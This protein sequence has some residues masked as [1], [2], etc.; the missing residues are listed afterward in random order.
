MNKYSA[1]I[2][3][4]ILCLTLSLSL[5]ACGEK[6]PTAQKKPGSQSSK[7]QI[8]SGEEIGSSQE[9]ASSGEST[10]NS[11]ENNSTDG[12][13]AAEDNNSSE[14][15]SSGGGSYTPSSGGSNTPSENASEPSSGNNS[16][17]PSENSSSSG[18]S[19]K[20]VNRIPLFEE[21]GT[22][23]FRL[24]RGEN[25]SSMVT[26]EVKAFRSTLKKRRITVDY[27]IDRVEE[28]KEI[29]EVLIGE[30]NRKE[31]AETLKLLKKNRST[32]ALDFIIKYSNNKICIV[33]GSDEVLG[34][35]LNQFL[36]DF[37]S[38]TKTAIPEDY[39]VIYENTKKY[40]VSK[41]G[42]TEMKNYSIVKQKSNVSYIV[43]K[44][45]TKLQNE[46]F[47]SNGHKVDLITDKDAERKYEIIIGSAK[48]P[49]VK[50]VSGTN[51]YEIRVKDNKVFINGN[52]DFALA[53]A[54]ERFTE[55]VKSGGEIKSTS[56][57]ATTTKEGYKLVWSEE[58]D[59]D[60]LNRNIWNVVD[61]TFPS[62][63]S[64]VST[65]FADR[66]ENLYVKDGKLHMIGTF[67]GNQYFGSEIE[68]KA[69]MWYQYGYVEISARVPAQVGTVPAFWSR[70]SGREIW[71]EIDFFECLTGTS[72]IKGTLLGW[73]GGEIST[74]GWGAY[75]VVTDDFKPSD[76]YYHFPEGENIYDEYHTIGF[77]WDVYS[78][79]WTCDGVEFARFDGLTSDEKYSATFHTPIHLLLSMQT[80]VNNPGFPQ[81]N[82][83]TDWTK[84]DFIIDYIRLYQKDGQTLILK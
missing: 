30:T 56:G 21:D 1:K 50:A 10:D 23:R 82:A 60:S 19:E 28:D 77:E 84:T 15:T 25:A 27:K 16:Y 31:S 39:E 14:N 76:T 81:P 33:A 58:F 20:E 42:G 57:K 40:V 26:A 73:P 7:P 3:S 65:A 2:I 54:V 69:S 38:S 41:I 51:A 37:I 74:H 80:A 32:Y 71:P 36:N 18:S 4:I 17:T 62:S 75:T 48:R 49:G 72:S 11:S 43:G 13:S 66:P 67:D 12:S 22:A 68:T 59:G 24:V 70:G 44:A 46:I 45:V 9:E 29:M 34:D 6:K 53:A 35:A 78:A 64:N 79:V 83:T 52:G 5:A 61:R 55:M 47:S 63:V 8:T